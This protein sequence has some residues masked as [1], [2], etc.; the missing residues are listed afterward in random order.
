MDS[1][2]LDGD[3]MGVTLATHLDGNSIDGQSGSAEGNGKREE[4]GRELHCVC[5]R[6]QQKKV[7]VWTSKRCARRREGV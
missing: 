3:N 6:E 5:T 7:L 4:S 2:R 1:R